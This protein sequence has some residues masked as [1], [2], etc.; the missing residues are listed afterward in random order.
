MRP[1]L[2]VMPSILLWWPTV[3]EEETGKNG[4]H[5]QSVL[6]AE[7]LWRPNSGCE[8]SEAVGGQFEQSD[9]G[10]PP[11]DFYKH[12]MQAPVHGLQKM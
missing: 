8:H 4:T 6:F 10:S 1:A 9:S 12:G 2:K 11:V 3:A 7:Y 5:C